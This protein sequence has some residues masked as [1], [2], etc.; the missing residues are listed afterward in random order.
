MCQKKHANSAK[1]PNPIPVGTG[2]SLAKN[3]WHQNRR[4]RAFPCPPLSVLAN[5][6]LVGIGYHGQGRAAVPTG[7]ESPVS[8]VLLT[9]KFVRSVGRNRDS[10]HGVLEYWVVDWSKRRIEVYR[11]Q[12]AVLELAATL[13]EGDLLVSPILPGFSCQVRELF[14]EIL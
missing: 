12:Q 9:E 2:V 13:Y 8:V 6:S 14:D 1:K 7:W 3:G 11:R 4:D 10:R 5:H